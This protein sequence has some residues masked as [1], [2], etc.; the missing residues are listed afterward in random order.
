MNLAFA[1]ASFLL[2]LYLEQVR[3][4]SAL[5]AGL[6]LLPSTATILVFNVI[7]AW[8]VTRIGSRTPVLIG[9]VVMAAGAAICGLISR[10]SS[11][12]VLAVGLPRSNAGVGLLST[13]SQTS[14]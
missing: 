3:G 12:W 9:L 4:Y 5:D 2:V 10:D 14:P 11:Y 6:L 13:P 1:G 7:G 8:M